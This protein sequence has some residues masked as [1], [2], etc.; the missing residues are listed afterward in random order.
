MVLQKWGFLLCNFVPFYFAINI[1][2]SR[3]KGNYR[4]DSDLDIAVEIIP[5]YGSDILST[6]IEFSDIWEIELQELLP[7]KVDLQL[8]DKDSP[9][10]QKG[11]DDSSVL[12]YVRG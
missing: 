11:V 1:Y 8:L 12:V 4:P 10:I 7:Y 6:W 2:G 9:T 3:I 5:D